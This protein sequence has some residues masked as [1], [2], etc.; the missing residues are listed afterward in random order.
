VRLADP[1]PDIDPS[2]RDVD[3][4][5]DCFDWHWWDVREI[6][7]SHDRFYPGRLPQL[8]PRFLAGEQIDE[9]FERWS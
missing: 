8:L 7:E 5:A 3:E 2:R 9:P 1:A 6:V 4:R